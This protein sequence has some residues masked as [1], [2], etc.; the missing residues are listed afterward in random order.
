MGV[1]FW[2]EARIDPESERS[3]KPRRLEQLTS[4]PRAVHPLV[5]SL[6]AVLFFFKMVSV[7]FPAIRSIP[8]LLLLSPLPFLWAQEPTEPP[9]NEPVV[10]SIFPMGGQPGTTLEVEMRGSNLA[11]AYAVGFE[12]D[13]L[14]AEVKKVEEIKPDEKKTED[15][16]TEE[17][18]PKT[19]LTLY[20]V[21]LRLHIDSAATTGTH[22]LRLVSLLGVSNAVPFLVDPDPVS[23]EMRTPHNT[24]NRAQRVDVPVVIS[25]K[26]SE[27][28]EVDYYDFEVIEGQY[29]LLEVIS[30]PFGVPSPEI[31]G[32]KSQISLYQPTGSW[33]D[34]HRG[35]WLTSSRDEPTSDDSFPQNSRLIYQFTE[36]GRY[37][38]EVSGKAGPDSSYQF[39]IAP[40]LSPR[41]P[42][43]DEEPAHAS[44]FLWRERGFRRPIEPDR[45]QSLWSRT[46]RV[47]SPETIDDV[48]STS[49]SGGGERAAS[50]PSG[51]PV[52]V[53]A[54]HAVREHEPNDT[55]SQALQLRVPS[56]IEG[57]IERPGDIDCFQFRVKPKQRLAFEIQTPGEEPP[58]FN[59]RLEVISREGHTVLTNVYSRIARN[60]TWYRKTIESKTIYTFEQGGEYYLQIRDFTSRFGDPSFV[61]RVLIRP[62][63]PHLGDFEVIQN[64]PVLSPGTGFMEKSR[65]DRINLQDG[66]AKKLVVLTDQ[67]EGFAGQTVLSVE[68]LPPGVQAFSATVIEPDQGPPVDEGDKDRFLPKT[69]IA[70]LMLLAS[71]DGET[72]PMPQL[73]RIMGR[74]VVEGKPGEP[75]LVGT[76]PLMVVR[77]TETTIG[78]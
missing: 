53:T 77:S 71:P 70:M 57:A 62:Q 44:D 61:Y 20:R 52:P 8:L 75:L 35:T 59:P 76:V 78:N 3:L 54:M 73:I 42:K 6:R 27:A 19:S 74:P 65:L 31:T 69:S 25:G 18:E 43:R 40:T 23:V 9:R 56:L 7:R 55:N 36:K 28:G 64:V 39:R 60:F 5:M 48:A 37:L 10:N 4:Q 11:G 12:D 1:Q 17:G 30:K 38:A 34:P 67:E 21:L 29:L 45:L 50:P 22:A 68:G 47:P 46:V 51:D 49:L 63:V 15:E 58:Q 41:L 72:T 14:Q 16:E 33:F 66:K 26:I 32:F 2:R 24:P 13:V